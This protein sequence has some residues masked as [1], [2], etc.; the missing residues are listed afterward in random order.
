VEIEKLMKLIFFIVGISF[1][2]LLIS[3]IGGENSVYDAE[4]F[5]GGSGGFYSANQ[6][7]YFL[8]VM[9]SIVLIFIGMGR[10]NQNPI[11]YTFLF[12]SIVNC[13][14]LTT[15][16][17]L[18]FAF[19]ALLLFAMVRKSWFL[20]GL[21]FASTLLALVRFYDELSVINRLLFFMDK[22]DLLWAL[23]SG[24]SERIEDFYSIHLS[25]IPGENK[26]I[27]FEMELFDSIAN[28][29]VAGMF[30]VLG[31][32]GYAIWKSSFSALALTIVFV[33]ISI[34]LLSGHF[35]NA[36]AIA[37]F[38]AVFFFILDKLRIRTK[39]H[40]VQSS[41]ARRQVLPRSTFS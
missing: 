13:F 31:F 18:A 25:L 4:G 27:N 10:E 41:F 34:I 38:L 19:L 9:I 22:N 21:V 12:L 14:I 37:P 35:F 15:K 5:G 24:R 11:S 20:V 3:A 2:A 16:S 17:S 39:F 7:S 28:L 36:I 29:G 40:T 8:I 30:F 6:Y 32:M 23:T 33:V 26:V 1:F